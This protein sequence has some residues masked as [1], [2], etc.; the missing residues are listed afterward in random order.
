MKKLFLLGLFVLLYSTDIP[1][2]WYKLL[3]YKKTIFGYESLIDDKNFFITKNGKFDPKKE[4]LSSIN[5]IKKNPKLFACKFPLRYTFLNNKYHLSTFSLNNCKKLQ[6]YLKYVKSNSV[7]IIFADASISK[8]A[9]MFGHT[10]L[11]F[12]KKSFS[13]I[14]SKSVNYAAQVNDKNGILFAF[15]GIFGFYKAYYNLLPYYK[16]IK[17]YNDIDSR[18]L[19]EYKLKFNQKEINRIL[20]HIYELKDIYSNYYFFKE[21]CSYNILYLIDVAKDT[22]LTDKYHFV[23][24]PLDTVKQL[25]KEKLITKSSYRASL[26]T[27]IYYILKK[28][29][30]K[31]LVIKISNGKVP[32]TI[33]LKKNLTDKERA[34][35]LDVSVL[36]L[37]Y[38]SR[39]KMIK[40][41]IYT[42]RFLNILKVRS[43]INYISN[44]KVKSNNNPLYSHN[45]RRVLL[46]IYNKK[47]IIG[48][49]FSYHSLEDNIFGYKKGFSLSFGDFRF[50]YDK[51]IKLQKAGIIELKS[52]SP[53]NDFFKPISWS[54]DFG[55]Y[56]DYFISKDTLIWKLAPSFGITKQINNLYIYSLLSSDIDYKKKIFVG[57]GPLFGFY[58]YKNCNFFE[59]KISYKKFFIEKNNYYN[60]LL[61]YRMKISTQNA[62]YINYEYK[63][64]FHKINNCFNI[65]Y[66]HYF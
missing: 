25:Y 51:K 42:K 63:K 66:Y 6:K 37:Q 11:R 46:G 34:E 40:H 10:F 24:V 47:P 5:I 14:I 29:K 32:P 36:Y 30:H 39:K 48:Y 55:I 19:W 26:Q 23:T 1:S 58:S 9:S 18:D 17:Q 13:P 22:N 8:P 56:R 64:S 62:I 41:N 49:R 35:I 52:F 53:R 57:V 21:N 28:I 20:L 45:S 54:V 7:Y 3:H 4:F 60:L 59:G 2:Y 38:L 44:Y 15:K 16:K 33:V 61:G 43:K 50:T 65:F 12:D 31:N 27:Q